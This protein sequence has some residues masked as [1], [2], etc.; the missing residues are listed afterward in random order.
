MPSDCPAI[1]DWDGIDWSHDESEVDPLL[2]L[3]CSPLLE[4][5]A[6]P[7]T[8]VFTR[9]FMFFVWTG[10]LGHFQQILR[11]SQRLTGYLIG[12][13]RWFLWSDQWRV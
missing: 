3:P 10:T 4:S 6:S 13:A 9:N 7:P 1:P 11:C 8:T 2:V 5:M 12:G